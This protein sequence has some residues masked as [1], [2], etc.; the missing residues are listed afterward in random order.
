MVVPIDW[1]PRLVHGNTA[2]RNKWRLIGKGEGIHW[3][4][5]DEDISVKALLA[6]A[7]SG[8][9]PSS[10]KRWLEARSPRRRAVANLARD[11]SRRERR[12]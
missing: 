8:E 2:E 11:A 5:L 4:E 10:I 3:P 6:G 9:S 7:A 1:Y 12:P